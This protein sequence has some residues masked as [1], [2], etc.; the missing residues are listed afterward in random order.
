M[1]LGMSLLFAKTGT[2]TRQKR[3][4]IMHWFDF[5]RE[6]GPYLDVSII[7]IISIMTNIYYSYWEW[8]LG[9]VIEADIWA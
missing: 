8:L 2:K 7:R 1:I 3:R 4:V 5:K 6:G 9:L